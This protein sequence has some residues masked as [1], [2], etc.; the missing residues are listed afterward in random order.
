ML[1]AGRCRPGAPG[2]PWAQLLQ[3]KMDGGGQSQRC[4]LKELPGVPGMGAWG[5]GFRGS[6]KNGVMSG[7]G[8]TRVE[9]VGAWG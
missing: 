7:D 9:G 3:D 1:P 2:P 6:P 4:G 8:S 5:R